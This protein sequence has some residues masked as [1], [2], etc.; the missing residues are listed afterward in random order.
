MILMLVF[1]EDTVRTEQFV[2]TLTQDRNH[3]I[4]FQA[5]YRIV[6]P[7]KHRKSVKS[8]C[9]S[10]TILPQLILNKYLKE[11]SLLLRRLSR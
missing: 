3:T 9:Q 7:D 11:L 10:L 4:V 2:I 6:R 5:S 8:M 1:S